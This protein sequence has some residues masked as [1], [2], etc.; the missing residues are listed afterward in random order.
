MWHWVSLASLLCTAP[1]AS[2]KGVPSQ[3][4]TSTRRALPTAMR[5]DWRDGGLLP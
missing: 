3:L 1:D 2:T 4:C 5:L